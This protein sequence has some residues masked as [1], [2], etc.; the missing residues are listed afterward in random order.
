MR[1]K[2]KGRS[3]KDCPKRKWKYNLREG[4]E[5]CGLRETEAEDEKN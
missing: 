3:K 4:L 1:W 2:S 5:K